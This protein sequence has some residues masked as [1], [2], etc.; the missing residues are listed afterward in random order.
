MELTLCMASCEDY[1]SPNISNVRPQVLCLL[2][3]VHGFILTTPTAKQR[4]QSA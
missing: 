1:Q 4:L 3:W 2:T